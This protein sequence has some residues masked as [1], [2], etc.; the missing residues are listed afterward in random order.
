MC[1]ATETVIEIC[2]AY[3]TVLIVDKDVDFELNVFKIS[4]DR[5][6]SRYGAGPST[7]T[8]EELVSASPNEARRLEMHLHQALTRIKIHFLYIKEI[9][10]WISYILK[11]RIAWYGAVC[12]RE[13][14]TYA[15]RYAGS[16]PW[17]RM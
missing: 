5:P 10:C 13:V 14:G 6:S 2:L 1:P 4:N 8:Q 9:V 7:N 3:A 15:R 17:I 12:L 11:G 16:W